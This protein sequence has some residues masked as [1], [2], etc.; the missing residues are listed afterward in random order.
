MPSIS[1]YNGAKVN[2]NSAYST[3]KP[4]NVSSTLELLKAASTSP[5]LSNFAFV[6]GGHLPNS[7]CVQSAI[8]MVAGGLQPNTNGYSQSK[9]VSELL[10]K[11][12]AELRSQ[13]Q[14]RGDCHQGI[15]IVKPG[16][17]IGT[18]EYGIANQNDFIWRLVAACVDINAH[19]EVEAES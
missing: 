14:A 9:L 3:L 1:L 19:S 5:A 2:W 6:S 11:K 17:I 16:Y 15:A 4:T 13:S 7:D 18:S 8:N 10:I 12:Y